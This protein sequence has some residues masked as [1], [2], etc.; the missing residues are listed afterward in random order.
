MLKRCW[1]KSASGAASAAGPTY[2][3]AG[4]EQVG[5]GQHERGRPMLRLLPFG[6]EVILDHLFRFLLRLQAQTAATPPATRRD[7]A[8]PHRNRQEFAD[9]LLAAQRDVFA[10]IILDDEFDAAALMIE[11]EAQFRLAERRGQRLA[12]FELENLV[13]QIVRGAC[14]GG[15]EAQPGRRPPTASR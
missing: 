2:F 15:G 12:G 14:L 5:L 11:M 10:L 4:V 13:G 3:S 8:T 1:M 6:G 9:R 7:R